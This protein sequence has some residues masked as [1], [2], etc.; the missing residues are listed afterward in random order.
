MTVGS[1]L[2]NRSKASSRKLS[3]EA[4]FVLNLRIVILGSGNCAQD[5]GIAL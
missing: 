5:V 2:W 4:L 1:H 3:G